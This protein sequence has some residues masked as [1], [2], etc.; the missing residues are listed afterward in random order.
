VTAVAARRERLSAELRREQFVTASVAVL[1]EAGYQAATAD[2]IARRAG[3]SKGLLWH[4]FTD[5]DD[6]FETTAR[7]VLRML[8]AAAAANI[9][10][11]APAPDVIRAAVHAAAA[12]RI[13]HGAERRAMREIVLNLRSP[14]GGPRFSQV[15]LD[16]LY[17]A[18]EAIF[19]RGQ[20]EGD[21]RQDLDPRLLA[22][23]YEGAVDSML[24]YLDAYPDTDSDTHADTL[25]AVLL[26]GIVST[27]KALSDKR[28]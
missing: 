6:L 4:Y 9:D 23:T 27:A 21:F 13:T 2:T 18:Q 12:L 25:A 10:I 14:D 16:E 3:V 20:V 28:P 7:Q 17:T 22:V 1:A 8:R 26:G 24:E 5:L 11:R 15:D 19:R